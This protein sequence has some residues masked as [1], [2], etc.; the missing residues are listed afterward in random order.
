M[1]I[2]MNSL[3]KNNNYISAL[4]YDWLTRFYDPIM[5]WTMREHAFKR[6]LIWQ[7]DI[8]AGQPVLDLGC[9]TAT[10]TIML[11]GIHPE[12]QVVGL[13]GD[14]KALSIAKRK[15][16]KNGLDIEF[17]KGLSFDLDF[18]DQSFDVVVSSLLFHHLNREDKLRTLREVFRI[19]KPA[20]ELHI[21]DWGRPE[22]FFMRGA[23]LV[24]QLLDGF[25]TTGDSV[26]GKLLQYMEQAGF[27][28]A[29]ETKRFATLFGTVCLYRGSLK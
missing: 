19:L 24:V 27:K 25:E 28:N 15:I 1:Y 8:K 20:G 29:G 10:L 2:A 7:A 5:Q 11:K 3:Q 23:F 14:E 18:T 17:K 12:A 16:A 26:Q 6:Q 21:A 22:N 9:G 13:D 4:H